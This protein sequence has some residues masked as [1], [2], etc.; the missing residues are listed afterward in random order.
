[1]IFPVPPKDRGFDHRSLL[2]RTHVGGPIEL[3][4]RSTGRPG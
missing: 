2:R 4:D 1:M 3:H